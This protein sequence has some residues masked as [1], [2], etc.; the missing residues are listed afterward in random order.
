[1]NTVFRAILVI[2]CFTT[3]LGSGIAEA[4]KSKLPSGKII[5]SGASGQL[6]GEV[7]K[8]L[9]ARGVAP[10]D[11]ILVSR[12]PDALLEYIKQGAS[13]RY[14]DP[15]RPESLAIAY[16]GGASMLLISI[17]ITPG[18]PMSRSE[19]HQA[20]FE[21]AVKDGVQ[22]IVYTSYLGADSGTSLVAQDHFKS[23]AALRASGVKY[24][25]ILRNG[26]Y[27]DGFVNLAKQMVASGKAEVPIS[28]IKMANVTREDCAAAAAGALL[29]PNA[30]DKVYDITGPD[31]LSR[32]ELAALVSSV[33]GKTIEILLQSAEAAAARP[34]MGGEG[35]GVRS[36]A[37]RELAGRP[38]TTMREFLEMHMSE[39]L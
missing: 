20:A 31:L 21:A 1:M 26:G 19:A 23:E 13:A 14:G 28:D 11:L 7:I 22:H 33:T 30:R 15:M 5:V 38:A 36:D 24:W 37:V 35:M 10:R 39:I 9:L 6:G 18:A 8:E 16:K 34:P 2:A 32:R 17:G 29:N 27:A 25:T 4:A 12:T 3:V